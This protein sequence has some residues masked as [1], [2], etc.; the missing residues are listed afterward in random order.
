MNSNQRR[1]DKRRWRYNVRYGYT[2]WDRYDEMWE[3]LTTTY[4]NH[5]NKVWRE[6]HGHIGDYWQFEDEEVMTMFVLKFGAGDRT[7]E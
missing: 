5:S 1:K 6:K 3:W 4:G 2:H 7:S